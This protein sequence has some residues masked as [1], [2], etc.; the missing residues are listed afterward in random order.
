MLEDVEELSRDEYDVGEILSETFLDLD[1]IA[2][3]LDELKKFKPTHDDKLSALK[4]LA[5]DRSGAEEEQGADLHRVHGH[6]PLSQGG[7]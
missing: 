1:Q 7:A 2:D 6:R 4:T 3:F 5:Q